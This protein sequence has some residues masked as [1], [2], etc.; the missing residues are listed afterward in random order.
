MTDDSLFNIAPRAPFE[1]GDRIN[2]AT[3][4][5]VQQGIVVELI[6]ETDQHEHQLV[7][8]IDGVRHT[9]DPVHCTLQE[10]G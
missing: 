8:A 6:A 10:N 5:G 7:I 2:L 4:W 3:L 1:T 9:V